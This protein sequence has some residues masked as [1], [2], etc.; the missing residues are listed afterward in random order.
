MNSQ[1]TRHEE[2]AG[3]NL[4]A[5]NSHEFGISLAYTFLMLWL[6][7]FSKVMVYYYDRS[8]LFLMCD[9]AGGQLKAEDDCFNY[10]QL[11]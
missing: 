3:G 9:D 1:G 5:V 10:L 11:F 2:G 4:N 8:F 7:H 6:Q